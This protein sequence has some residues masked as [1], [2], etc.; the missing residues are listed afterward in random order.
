MDKLILVIDD[1]DQKN[2]IEDLVREAKK[3]NINLMYRQFNVGSPK[4]PE[5]MTDGMI[6]INK[7]KAAYKERFKNKGLVFNMI[8]CDWDLSDEAIDGAE[9]LRRMGSECFNPKTPRILYSSLLWQKIEEQLN[10]YDKENDEA[11]EPV[12]KY[13]ASLINGNYLAFVSREELKVPVLR[14]ICESESLD[15]LIEDTLL[16]YPD[17]V[18]AVGHGHGLEGKSFSEV[19][20]LIQNAE[21]NYDFKRDIIQEVIQYLTHRQ[22]KKHD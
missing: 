22:S 1:D 4:E 21:V 7:V 6:D 18:M 8:L 11:K 15:F 19:A 17:C 20:K 5:L 14:H 16:R 2:V 13:I 12:I 9:L 10:K 3:K